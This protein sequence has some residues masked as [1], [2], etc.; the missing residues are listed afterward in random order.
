MQESISCEFNDIEQ[1]HERQH[2][3]EMAVI[4]LI[5]DRL[6]SKAVI[7]IFFRAWPIISKNQGFSP[8]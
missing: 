2:L 8:V 3:A 5:N 6:Y 7:S 4:A 1:E